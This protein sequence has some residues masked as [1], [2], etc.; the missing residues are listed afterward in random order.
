MFLSFKRRI[1]LFRGILLFLLFVYFPATLNAQYYSLGQ[2]PSSIRWNVINTGHFKLIY[3]CEYE[4]KAQGV[5]SL[6]DYV[7]THGSRTLE[8]SARKMPVIIHNRDIIPNAYSMWAP[9]RLELFTCPPQNTY[10][11][12]WMEQLVIHEYRHSIQMDMLNQGFTKDLGYFFGEQAVA[13]VSGL[14]VPMWFMEG[15]AVCTE[16]A[17]S[18]SGRGRVPSFEMDIRSQ[19]LQKGIYSYDKAVFGSFRD[20]VPDQYSLGYILVANH[21]KHFG[22]KSWSNALEY[23]G[24]KPFMINPFNRGLR[25]SSGLN[26]KEIYSSSM[27]EMDSLWKLQRSFTPVTAFHSITSSP[28]YNFVRYK[29]PHYINDTLFIAEKSGMDD[30]SRFVLVDHK[31]QESILLTPGFFSSESFSMVP[32]KESQTILNKPGSFTAD[33]LSLSRGLLTWTEREADPRWQNRNYSVIKIF[34]FKSGKIQKL[35]KKSRYF[36]PCLSP[37]DLTLAA[38]KMTELDTSS[39]V[40]LDLEDGNEVRTLVSSGTDFHMNPS[41]SPDGNILVYT[42]LNQHGKRIEVY[43]LKLDRIKVLLPPSFNEISNPSFAES[44]V[45][46]NGSYGGIENVYALDTS[47]GAVYQVTSA[48]FGACNARYNPNKKSIVYSNYDAEGYHLA[49]AGFTPASWKPLTEVV[50]HSVALY[51]HLLT[52]ETGVVDSLAYSN[53]KYKSS[54]YR[55]ISHLF[56]FHSWVPAYTNY[57]T[58]ETNPGISFMSQ[59]LLSTATTI[60]GYEYDMADHTGDFR[61]NFKYEGFYPVLEIDASTGK[62]AGYQEDESG[63]EKRYTWNETRLSSGISL[64]LLINHG[65]YYSGIQLQMKSSLLSIKNN[66]RTDTTGFEGNVHSLDY[67]FYSSNIL[68][69]G[70]RDLYPRWGQVL[71]LNF[72]HSPWSDISY[73]RIG[74]VETL[75]FFPGF[76]K[77]HGLRLYCGYQAKRMGDHYYANLVNLPRGYHTVAS[78]H[79]YSLAVTYKMPLFYPDL[80]LGS[81]AYFKRIKAAVFYDHFLY[82]SNNNQSLLN[83]T[84]IELS[85]DM[86]FL[87]FLL[88]F[89]AGLRTGYRISDRKAFV[90][91]L[92]SINLSI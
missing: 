83:S 47:N 86:H 63:Q 7:Y 54:R 67:R 66:T 3:P 80:N 46:F 33:N 70:I 85:A 2:D 87:R 21:R 50:D 92:F 32:G 4:Q 68:K 79:A 9:R 22:Y 25:I 69:Q 44:F 55:K 51:R 37:S 65:K 77:H 81:I 17:L 20:F 34:D 19:V 40:I 8:H 62:G 72:R 90:D 26:K 5:A 60:V 57:L 59:N 45:L 49:E 16:T 52:E 28:Q 74:S 27:K 29:Y 42:V 43:D 12:Y 61:L 82:S 71:E 58:S 76:L 64:P 53:L 88:P 24:R 35:T 78:D 18:H 84:G 10:S 15:D 11:Q 14:F 30:I 6:F 48:E 56:N 38:V 75:L 73:G 36:A 39:I 13:A 23:V 1:F 31:G 91:F 89:D 41:F